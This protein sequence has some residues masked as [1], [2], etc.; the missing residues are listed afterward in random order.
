VPPTYDIEVVDLGFIGREYKEELISLDD[1]QISLSYEKGENPVVF[2]HGFTGAKEDFTFMFVDLIKMGFSPLAYD[3]RGH[4]NTVE[5]KTRPTSGFNTLI[6]D[7]FKLMDHLGI[8]EPIVIGHSMGGMVLGEALLK[9]P[10]YFKAV[11][12]MD[13][14]YGALNINENIIS[15]IEL[16]VKTGGITKLFEAATSLGMFD[17]EKNDTL[18]ELNKKMLS[19][20]KEKFLK[21]DPQAFIRLAKD[22]SKRKT[23]LDRLSQITV[24]AMVIAGENDTGFF[25]A[26]KLIADSLKDSRFCVIKNAGHLPQFENKDEFLKVFYSFLSEFN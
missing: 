1:L 10:E 21:T 9:N 26:S 23:I 12:F 20:G 17:D 2:I 11:I 7:F 18:S 8:T 15:A 14:H 25:E 4:G 22:L 5:L 13:T 19:F 6:E 3:Q 16:I 24:P